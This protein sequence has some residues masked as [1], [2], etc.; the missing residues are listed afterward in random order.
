M[1]KRK[2]L[3]E[4]QWLTATASDPLLKFL[5]QHCR[6]AKVAGGKRKL[7]LF[8]VACC[9]AAWHLFTNEE[10][11][12]AVEVGERAAD[13]LATRVEVREAFAAANRITIGVH[14]RMGAM[15]MQQLR[16]GTADFLQINRDQAMSSAA[17]YTASQQGGVLAAEI[18]L[19]SV[20][21]L[22][23]LVSAEVPLEQH[24]RR[25][26]ELDAYHAD[27]VRDVFGNPFRKISVDPRWLTSSVIDLS[28][29]I[30][31]ERAWER[32]PI[33]ADALMDAGCD[34]EDIINHCRS[35]RPHA[36]G[37]WVVDAILGKG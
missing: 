12:H 30:Y 5:Q 28:K 25:Q 6:I 7:R 36:R 10:C 9:R 17:A 1:A 37:C 13:G 3:T 29:S 21:N 23:C 32:M 4:E 26:G 11:R 22:S 20:I 34:N 24:R 31:E 19:L 15:D 35:D 16:P 8:S 2:P 33:L 18:V 27:L 14:Q